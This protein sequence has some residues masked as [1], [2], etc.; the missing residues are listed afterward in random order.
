[1]GEPVAMVSK[2]LSWRA[3]VLP[4]TSASSSPQTD[5]VLRTR[6]KE[7]SNKDSDDYISSQRSFAKRWLFPSLARTHSS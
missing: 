1:M 6:K 4:K 5:L 7:D 2:V 3:K